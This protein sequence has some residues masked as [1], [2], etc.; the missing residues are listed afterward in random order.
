MRANKLFNPFA[1]LV[2]V[3][4]GQRQENLPLCYKH[5][6]AMSSRKIRGK[7]HEL[8]FSE[9]CLKHLNVI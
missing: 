5:V 7:F 9:V 3:V 4:P 8:V 1:Q 2:F 6:I